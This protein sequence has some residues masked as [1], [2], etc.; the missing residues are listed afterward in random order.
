MMKVEPGRCMAPPVHSTLNKVCSVMKTRIPRQLLWTAALCA[1]LAFPGVPALSDEA[2]TT[3]TDSASAESRPAE[4]KPAQPRLPPPLPDLTSARK[5]F[6][7]EDPRLKRTVT[8]ILR[9]RPITELLA[10]LT[11]LTAVKL[12]AHSDIRD[13]KITAI[14]RGAP[15][16]NL[17]AEVGKLMSWGW[18]R[19]TEESEIAYRLQP[20]AGLRRRA[21]FLRDSI[22][23]TSIREKAAE[24]WRSAQPVLEAWLQ[25]GGDI[26]ALRGV[27]ESIADRIEQDPNLEYRIHTMALMPPGSRYQWLV[28][29]IRYVDQ[30]R[31]PGTSYALVE[32]KMAGKKTSPSGKDPAFARKVD[33]KLGSDSALSA[34]LEAVSKTAEM[35]LV[36]DSYS[37]KTVVKT[38]G[39]KESPL[40]DVLDTIAGET[41][42]DWTYSGGFVRF[43][44]RTW[45]LDELRDVPERLIKRWKDL[46]EKQGRLYFQDYVGLVSSLTDDQLDGLSEAGASNPLSEDAAV[47]LRYLPQFRFYSGL[48]DPQRNAAWSGAGLTM[49]RMTREQKQAFLRLMALDRPLTPPYWE[50]AV[51]FLV[52]QRG[53]QGYEIIFTFDVEGTTV[54]DQR[55]RLPSGA[56]PTTEAAESSPTPET[57]EIPIPPASGGDGSEE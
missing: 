12:E 24:E 2:A 35:S 30:I 55:I 31:G 37:R 23:N 44:S 29:Q 57:E 17:M 25:S 18:Q 8:L 47:A 53:S 43:R 5:P 6:I 28:D 56:S 4:T 49:S 1:A 14:A 3:P 41:S 9:D 48:G 34:A 42:Y 39:W 27:D 10:R 20:Q 11:E 50:P 19:L 54:W 52:R 36:A 40:S 21:Q 46:K 22:V 7:E 16:V 38:T 45:F 51:L 13:R 26:D 33:V 15:V 32:Q